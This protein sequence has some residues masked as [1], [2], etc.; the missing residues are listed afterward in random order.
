MGIEFARK[1]QLRSTRIA[2]KLYC[3]KK[4]KHQKGNTKYPTFS[5]APVRKNVTLSNYINDLNERIDI[6]DFVENLHQ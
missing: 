2:R 6:I 4:Y 3:N 5:K 1:R